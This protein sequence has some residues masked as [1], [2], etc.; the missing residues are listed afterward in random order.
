[1]YYKFMFHTMY[2]VLKNEINLNFYGTLYKCIKPT[3]LF[4]WTIMFFSSIVSQNLK[5]SE[6]LLNRFPILNTIREIE[7][8]EARLREIRQQFRVPR[9]EIKVNF[10]RFHS[11]FPIE[12]ESISILGWFPPFF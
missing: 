7:N 11:L 8:T 1:M 12:F 6:D 2:N 10:N 9:G 3:R 4:I 5:M